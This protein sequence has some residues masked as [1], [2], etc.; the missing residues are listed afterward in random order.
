MIAAILPFIQGALMLAQLAQT[1]Q[2]PPQPPPPPEPP[3]TLGWDEAMRRATE[4]LSPIYDERM[5]QTLA[6]VDK[7]LISRGFFGQLPGAALAGS[8]AAEVERAKAAAI[9]SSRRADAITES[10]AGVSPTEAGC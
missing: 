10:G 3:P 9:A 7:D 2:G 6:G 5:Q 1:V 8:R 4:T